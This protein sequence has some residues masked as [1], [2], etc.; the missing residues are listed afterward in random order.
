M[1]RI[2]REPITAKGAIDQA[3]AFA[4]DLL[5][6]EGVSR[7]LKG[8][9][10]VRLDRP[11]LPPRIGLLVAIQDELISLR[12]PLIERDKRQIGRSYIPESG[13]RA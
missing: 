6:D 1:A 12:V 4:S 10:I 8:E 13:A 11:W 3:V 7:D 9:G 5:G 2:G